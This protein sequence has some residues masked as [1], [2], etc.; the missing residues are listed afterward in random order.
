MTTS[1]K[2]CF[3]CG[4]EK[5]LTDFYKHCKM[6]DGHLNKCVDCTKR[7]VRQHRR[8]KRYRNKVLEY[9]R[10]RG[11]RQPAEYFASYKTRFPEKVK[12]QTAVGNAVRDGRLHKLDACEYCG[13]DGRKSRLEA[14]HPSYAADMRLCV[15]WLCSACHSQ[16]HAGVF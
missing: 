16:A 14:H 10:Q 3:K 5:P 7:D 9:D 13:E 2:T 12:A 6:A 1:I 8:D 15:T 11:N 4:A